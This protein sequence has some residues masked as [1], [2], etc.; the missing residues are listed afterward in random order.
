M[1]TNSGEQYFTFTC[2]A[3]WLIYEKCRLNP[4]V[5]IEP[6][7]FADPNVVLSGLEAFTVKSTNTNVT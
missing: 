4:S 3:A 5:A 2:L 7:Q 6:E 1:Q